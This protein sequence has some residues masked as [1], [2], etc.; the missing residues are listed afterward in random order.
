MNPSTKRF[1]WKV[2]IRCQLMGSLPTRKKMK[3]VF[4]YFPNLNSKTLLSIQFC[5][6][7]LQTSTRGACGRRGTENLA[8]VRTSFSS[9]LSF[10]SL[11]I[12]KASKNKHQWWLQ[13][14]LQQSKYKFQPIVTR[15][16]SNKQFGTSG[17]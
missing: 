8:G 14:N 3:L 12:F 17:Y 11:L 5:S 2:W 4:Q 9:F 1:F 16:I 15:K 13:K 10:L 6:V 7:S